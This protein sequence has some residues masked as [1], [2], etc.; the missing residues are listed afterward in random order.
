M[1]VDRIWESHAGSLIWESECGCPILG[2]RFQQ[3]DSGN[4]N[5]GVRSWE[6]DSGTLDLGVRI[7]VIRFCESDDRSPNLGVVGSPTTGVNLGPM[8]PKLG[9]PGDSI[10]GVQIEKDT[11]SLWGLALVPC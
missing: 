8:R 1:Q 7:W 2:V 9:D 5:L 6:F 10:L 11:L 3:F 4:P